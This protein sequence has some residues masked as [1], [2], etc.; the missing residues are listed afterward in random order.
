MVTVSKSPTGVGGGKPTIVITKGTTGTGVRPQGSQFIV[1][2]TAPNIRT[3]QGV[4]T[5]QAGSSRTVTSSI[6]VLPLSQST[7]VTSPGVKMIV[8]SSAS[9]GGTN[10]NTTGLSKPITITVPGQQGGVP[11]TVTLAAKPATSGAAILSTST[12][13]IL[14]MPSQG[15]MPGA[16]KQAITIGGKPVTVQVTTAG[17]QKTVTLL[18]N[19]PVLGAAGGTSPT[20]QGSSLA[21]VLGAGVSGERVM[22][23]SSTATTTSSTT[24]PRQSV[25]VLSSQGTAQP[26]LQFITPSNTTR[27]Q[28]MTLQ[29]KQQRQPSATLAPTDGPATTDAALAAL[30]AEAGL[31]DPPED[32]TST[33]LTSSVNSEGSV[34]VGGISDDMSLT[35]TESI[36]GST[37]GRSE[38]NSVE[39]LY[40]IPSSQSEEDL[41]FTIRENSPL[42]NFT[43]SFEAG[44]P[45]P[46][47]ENIDSI[48]EDPLPSNSPSNENAV[49]SS[50]NPTNS[51]VQT[52]VNADNQGNPG[53]PD[54][55]GNVGNPISATNPENPS[56]AGGND[57]PNN[58]DN[59]PGLEDINQEAP[60]ENI[61]RQVG[62]VGKVVTE[63]PD[64]VDNPG[65]QME[66]PST[67]T[68]SGESGGTLES[69]NT[70]N[71]QRKCSIDSTKHRDLGDSELGFEVPGVKDVTGSVTKIKVE[72]GVKVEVE[73]SVKVDMV[74]PVVKDELENT[75]VDI[76]KYPNV[77]DIED[78]NNSKQDVLD[79]ISLHQTSG[80]VVS[81]G[82]SG[83]VDSADGLVT[84]ASAA[85][86]SE[87]AK[88]EL[89]AC[90][91]VGQVAGRETAALGS[92]SVATNG[93]KSESKEKPESQKTSA[94]N[95][96]LK[97]KEAQWYDVGII[98]GT[99]CLVQSY[100][101]PDEDCS[102]KTPKTEEGEEMKSLEDDCLLD[103]PDPTK[104][105]DR[106]GQKKVELMP[107]TAYKFR[108]AGINSCGRGAWSEHQE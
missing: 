99:S 21:K 57:N 102:L 74:D 23:V 69:L 2:T 85:I 17:G 89:D 58:P 38:V 83:L 36:E 80:K 25:G 97:K 65:N 54:T 16:K 72:E 51:V 43:Q 42:D 81:S 70:R 92:Y 61:I 84:L 60:S 62:D 66:K 101:V 98:K 24:S 7:N 8:V 45:E 6:N 88:V 106:S 107:G 47:T 18:T 77:G 95:N 52:L 64:G 59:L 86:R 76:F 28:G 4:S 50:N 32:S 48:T 46:N 87:K 71:N 37:L 41:S 31:I 75:K 12:G 35:Q 22:V 11:K 103:R 19:Q 68:E 3:M 55:D 94:A 5:A 20:A 10:T 67:D 1:V 78:V 105:P 9:M 49:N 79:R 90:D 29:S 56:S 13:Q 63:N 27:Q 73:P 108:V 96:V 34:V 53:S 33:N 26:T 91:S 100:Y 82:E 104:E 40:I 30:A 14:T 44:H 93:R 15:L 39:K